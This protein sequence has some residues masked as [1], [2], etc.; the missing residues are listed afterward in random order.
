[1]AIDVLMGFILNIFPMGLQLQSWTLSLGL[2]TTVFALLAAY[3]RRRDRVKIER[4]PRPR[5]TI[6]EYLLFGLAILVTTVAV[7]FSVIRPP[8]TQAAFTQFWMLPSNQAADSC[9]VRIGVHNFE[10]TT[11][12]YRVVVKMNGTL[13]HTWPSVALA[14]QEEWDQLVSLLP[15]MTDNMYVEGQLYQSNKPATFYRKTNL[16]LHLLS[17]GKNGKALQCG[18][19]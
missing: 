3:L 12:E 4:R 16:M 7:W 18:T 19:A 15:G 14:P 13:I 8:A 6:Y 9:A 11:V 2:V 10:S 1:M 17:N 5:I